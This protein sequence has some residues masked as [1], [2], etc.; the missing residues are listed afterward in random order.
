[1]TALIL[2]AYYLAVAV[3]WT[4]ILAGFC[5]IGLGAWALIDT[6]RRPAQ[7]FIAA[8]KRTKGFWLAVNAVGVLVVAFSGLTSFFG[9][10]G[11]VANAVYLADV[12]PALNYYR[13]VR[14][15]VR[16]RRRGQDGR[17]GAGGRRR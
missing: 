9:L 16:I 12:R 6:L 3:R 15:R 13:P 1:M 5:A 14:V 7:N 10:L 11:V 4:W 8:D 17:G 2:T